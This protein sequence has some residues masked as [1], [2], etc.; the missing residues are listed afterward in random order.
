M[1]LLK[2]ESGPEQ[3]R[4]VLG[5]EETPSACSPASEQGG[6]AFGFLPLSEPTKSPPVF[7]GSRVLWKR[8]FVGDSGQLFHALKYHNPPSTKR[9]ISALLLH[10]VGLKARRLSVKLRTLKT[11]FIDAHRFL[12]RRRAAS[13][14]PHKMSAGP[15]GRH[16]PR[17][18]RRRRRR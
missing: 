10:T 8:C 6:C 18:R 7:C 17:G 14:Q 13:P 12:T 5:A 9:G 16:L 11:I 15:N 2:E 4:E 1:F 3:L